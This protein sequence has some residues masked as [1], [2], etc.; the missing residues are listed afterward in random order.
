MFPNPLAAEGALVLVWVG[1]HFTNAVCINALFLAE[2]P[3]AEIEFAIA[4][5]CF[6]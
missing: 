6:L 4:P 3:E 2:K 5:G 1:K